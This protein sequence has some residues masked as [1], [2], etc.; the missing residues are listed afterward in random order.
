M[1]IT[2][3]TNVNP[4]NYLFVN[5]KNQIASLYL[6]MGQKMQLKKL[7]NTKSCSNLQNSDDSFKNNISNNSFQ[8]PNISMIKNLKTNNNNIFNIKI[9]K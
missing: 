6:K 7:K 9:F 4:N 2:I 1:P 8:I 3:T 5:K